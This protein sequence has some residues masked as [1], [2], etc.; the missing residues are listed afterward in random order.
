M[1]SRTNS[2]ANHYSESHSRIGSVVLNSSIERVMITLSGYTVS[3][4]VFKVILIYT[5]Y[6]NFIT[7]FLNKPTNTYNNS[8]Q[9]ELRIA[10]VKASRFKTNHIFQ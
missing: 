1:F 2:I 8:P 9:G 4:L 6:Y 10:K 5:D 3:V 7:R